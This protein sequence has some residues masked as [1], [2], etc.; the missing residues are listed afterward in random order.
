MNSRHKRKRGDVTGLLIPDLYVSVGIQVLTGII[1]E[2]FRKRNGVFL[3]TSALLRFH[4]VYARNSII[5]M[6]VIGC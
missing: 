3:A 1:R 5:R 4:D 2:L 6:N